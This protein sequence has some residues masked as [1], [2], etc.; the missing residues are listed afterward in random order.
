MELQK[1]IEVTDFLKKLSNPQ[2]PTQQTQKNPF[3]DLIGKYVLIRHN[4]E[5][6]NCGYFSSHNEVGFFLTKSRKLWRWF[7]K[8]SISL[9]ALCEKGVDESKTKATPIVEKE[10]IPFNG[11][12]S[13]KEVTKVSVI[14]QIENLKEAVQ[15]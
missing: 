6:V 7:A 12:C 10:F 2:Q 8:E 5:G 15:E 1:L 13:I 11:L 14:N 3:D 9:F 4:L